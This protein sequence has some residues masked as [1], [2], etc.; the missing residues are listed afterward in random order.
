MYI[1]TREREKERVGEGYSERES[2]RETEVVSFLSRAED[3]FP[4]A[5][6]SG[7]CMCDMTPISM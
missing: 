4:L 7:G 3:S 5:D 1:S 2:A 6:G